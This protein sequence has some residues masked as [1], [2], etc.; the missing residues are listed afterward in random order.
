[1]AAPHGVQVTGE[2]GERYDSVLTAERARA[3]RRAAP[4]LRRQ[5]AGACSGP[6][7][8]RYAELAAGGTLDF[9]DGDEGHPRGRLAGRAAR[10]G[11]GRPP[12]R[13]H[14]A[15]RPQD[16]DQR[17]QLRR[18]GVAGRPRGRQHAA[19]GR[20]SSRASSTC[21]TRSTARSTSPRPRARATRSAD[22]AGHDRRAAARLA[23]AG[24]AHHRRRRADVRAAWST[25]RST[26]STARQR[27]LDAGKGPYFY[28]PKME[29]HLEARLWNDV[30]LLA[31]DRL[32][33]PARHDPGHRADRDLPR[34]VRDGGDP[35]RAARALR[36][37]QRRALGLHL[38]RHQEVPRPAGEE[39][40][41][42]DRNAGDHDGAVHARLHRA[43]G[44]HLPQAR[45]ARDRR[46]GG[47]HPEQGPGGQ[48]GGVRRRSATTRPARPA[49]ASTAPG[50]PTP[51]WSRSARR[52]STGPRRPAQPARQEARGRP[53][54]RGAAAR[55]A[56]DPGRRH[57]GRAA[58]QHQRRHP[59]PR[60]LA[61]G[62]AARSASTT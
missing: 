26:S 54:H 3:P 55:R 9:L 44:A 11:P 51:G 14:R 41:L 52:S 46:H 22:G 45:R 6:A 18:Q 48:R 24:E 15:H 7:R 43:A 2:M 30:F 42:P 20:T 50:W 62:A 5:A 38:Q 60:R 36:R 10:A 32:G 23:P 34:G 59:V 28:L 27:Q 49:T 61:A 21:A 16:D 25:S 53:R 19:R 13:D 35:L 40:L 58:Q 47:V 1:M 8:T 37:P 33:H 29:S 31:Q 4:D 57:R 17:A 39:F 56:V 12:G